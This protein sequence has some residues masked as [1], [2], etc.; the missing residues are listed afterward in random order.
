MEYVVNKV[1]E[2][3][4]R[5]TGALLLIDPSLIVRELRVVYTGIAQASSSRAYDLNQRL[6]AT[7]LVGVSHRLPH[8]FDHTL[9]GPRIG[10]LRRGPAGHMTVRLGRQCRT[11]T[12]WLSSECRSAILYFIEESSVS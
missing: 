2:N 1:A 8:L 6:H 7:S 5:P 4:V 3:R 9:S 10:V 11:A 12:R